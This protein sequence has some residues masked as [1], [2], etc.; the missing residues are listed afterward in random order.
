MGNGEKEDRKERLA[1]VHRKTAEECLELL[2]NNGVCNME[3]C[4]GFGKTTIMLEMA[5]LFDDACF[6]YPRTIIGKEAGKKDIETALGLGLKLF[7]YSKIT[8]MYISGTIEK[9][10]DELS[11]NTLFIIDESHFV[12]SEVFSQAYL[13]MR[14][15]FPEAYFLGATATPYRTYESVSVTD[16]YFD[17]VKPF[18][19]T[20]N[21][22]I[23]DGIFKKALY[24][25][26]RIDLEEK[27]LEFIRSQ[28]YDGE[29]ISSIVDYVTAD[30]LEAIKMSN[31]ST[32]IRDTI[33]IGFDNNLPEYMKY[34]IF[35]PNIAMVEE[36][37]E[38]I[39]SW[40]ED[41]FPEYYVE[42][43]EVTSRCGDRRKVLDRMVNLKEEKGKIDLILAV[44]MVSYGYHVDNITS[45]VLMR[46]T[47]SDI[48][49]WQQVGRVFNAFS[50]RRPIIIDFVGSAYKFSDS[51]YRVKGT[52]FDSI[53]RKVGFTTKEG[54]YKE[55]E[56]I[57]G[58]SEYSCDI[59]DYDIDFEKFFIA[60]NK[61]LQERLNGGLLRLV[62][63]GKLSPSIACKELGCTP[64]EFIRI[65]QD[66]LVYNEFIE[67]FGVKYKDWLEKVR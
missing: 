35:L 31:G 7:T 51:R 1:V 43:L 44:D 15:M 37:R 26:A 8:R 61:K 38:E 55:Q 67:K 66:K 50:D 46:P 42:C 21:D 19:Y 4:T 13:L 17:G 59:I 48:V 56:R 45:V 62:L 27:L 6:I 20:L 64:R 12:G 33:N 52:V 10:K 2:L 49:Y 41:A 60:Y 28:N 18:E 23:R 14:E 53:A 9:L 34:I 57:L 11:P 47:D 3:R 40:F 5:N 39:I 22:A 25:C 32:V 36:K 54:L 65:L 58:I 29:T 24:R 63:N 30:V 16:V